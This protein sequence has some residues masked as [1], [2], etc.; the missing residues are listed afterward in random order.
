MNNNGSVIAQV[1]V[2]PSKQLKQIIQI[3]HN[4]IKN[5]NWPEA[6][7]LADYN[8]ACPRIWTRG[9]RETNPGIRSDQSGTRTRDR[10]TTTFLSGSSRWP[11]QSNSFFRKWWATICRLRTNIFIFAISLW[12]PGKTAGVLAGNQA[13]F[14]LQF[15]W[16][17]C[18]NFP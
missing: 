3:E 12:K 11:M 8:W 14:M 17:K 9:Y 10:W 15:Y 18:N 4:I 1:L 16:R 13:M 7:Q 6:H 5:P 2:G